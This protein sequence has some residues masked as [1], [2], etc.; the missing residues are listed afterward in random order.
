[1]RRIKTFFVD[2]F[3]GRQAASRA[4]DGDERSSRDLHDPRTQQIHSDGGRIRRTLHRS[5]LRSGGF[6]GS[7]RIRHRNPV[8]R[9]NHLPVLRNLR[10]RAERNGIDERAPLLNYSSCFLCRY[11][12]AEYLL[13]NV[14]E[15]SEVSGCEVS[16]AANMF[17]N[18][19]FWMK[20]RKTDQFLLNLCCELSI[21]SPLLPS[22]KYFK[23]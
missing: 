4:A 10:Q 8:G 7:D 13:L 21:R 15:M 11:F 2:N 20:E 16:K 9:H 14:S 19:F 22:C 3:S 6:H 5:A 18:E 1:L 23:T 17:L 12:V